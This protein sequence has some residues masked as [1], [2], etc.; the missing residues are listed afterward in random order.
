MRVPSLLLSAEAS[1]AIPIFGL[2]GMGIN[3]QI[4]IGIHD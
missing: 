1:L 3:I 2:L 4:G